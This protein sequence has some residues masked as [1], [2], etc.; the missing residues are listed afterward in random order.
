MPYRRYRARR[1]TKNARMATRIQRAW[2]RRGRRRLPAPYINK[3]T[4]VRTGF[5]NVQQKELD[6][7]F[8][9]EAQNAP[10]GVIK[11]YKFQAANLSQWSTLASLF[12]QYRINGIKMTFLPTTAASNATV[13]NPAATFAWSIDLDGDNQ[14]STFPELL[15]CSNCHTSAW[16]SQGGLT[17]YKKIFLRPRAHD[18]MITSL[19]NTGQPASFSVGLAS[20]KQWL[21]VSDRGLTDHFGVNVGW[22]FG[23]EVINQDQNLNVIITYYLQFRKVR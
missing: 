7:S 22:Y 17:P 1:S 2:R 19:D 16:T 3:S 18:A 5:L 9:L 13:N 6:T 11:K 12:D 14:I 8:V 23:N 15:E 21:D 10:N 20:R 4:S